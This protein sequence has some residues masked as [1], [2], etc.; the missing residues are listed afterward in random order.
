MVRGI[1]PALLAAMSAPVWHPVI[2]LDLDWPTGRIRAHSGT[3]T[4]AH[5]GHDYRGVGKFGSITSP[6]EIFGLGSSP[7]EMTLLGL[8]EDVVETLTAPTFQAAAR[9]RRGTVYIAASTEPG[10][11]TLIG[12]PYATATGYVDVVRYTIQ[13]EGDDRRLHGVQVS[14]AV[15][16][17]ARASAVLVHSA[18]DQ[19][20][21]F[22]A[23]TAGR[24][25]I[26]AARRISVMTWPAQ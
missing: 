16:P 8:P 10:G 17:S 13:R 19:Q 7:I 1:D 25:A 9:N 6:G 2:M 12:A 18:E 26:N 21:R 14:L 20:A 3:G 11:A 5:G 15:G 22:P 23:D 24:W 4:I